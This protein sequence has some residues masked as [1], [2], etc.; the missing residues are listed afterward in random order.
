[1]IWWMLE[2][3]YEGVG[4]YGIHTGD[5]RADGGGS[6]SLESYSGAGRSYWDIDDALPVA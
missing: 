2:G 1:M 4:K 5:D 3:D 6:G